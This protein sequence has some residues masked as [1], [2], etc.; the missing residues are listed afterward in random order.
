MLL[1]RGL[2]IES[3]LTAAVQHCEIPGTRLSDTG[4]NDL[5]SAPTGGGK[6][7]A[8]T[9]DAGKADP[10]FQAHLRGE[11]T[12]FAEHVDPESIRTLAM[13]LIEASR[14][15]IGASMEDIVSSAVLH[16]RRMRRGPGE[17][18][19]LARDHASP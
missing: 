19:E 12:S 5:L 1:G 3:G 10:A 17:L 13:G 4:E 7:A 14:L 11:N 8:V 9:H 2:A 6:T 16:D 18:R 15:D